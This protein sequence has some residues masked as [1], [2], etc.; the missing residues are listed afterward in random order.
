MKN[1]MNLMEWAYDLA[2]R[3]STPDVN[4]SNLYPGSILEV[5]VN[6]VEKLTKE[7]INKAERLS[8]KEMTDYFTQLAAMSIAVLRGIHGDE[9]IDGF[10]SAAMQDKIVAERIKEIIQ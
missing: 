5:D 7:A 4:E 6:K 9:F 3:I 1:G 10:L 8:Q 2:E